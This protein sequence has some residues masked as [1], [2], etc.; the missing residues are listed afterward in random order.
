MQIFYLAL[1]GSQ[2]RSTATLHFVFFFVKLNDDDFN[3]ERDVL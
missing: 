3:L 1:F 2:D